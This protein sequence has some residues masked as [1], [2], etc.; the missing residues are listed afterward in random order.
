MA[1]SASTADELS[2]LDQL[3]SSWLDD[4]LA[5]NPIVVGVERGEGGERRW[6]V[7]VHGD[8]KDVYS[9][10]LTLG[11]RT[12]HY[13]TYFMPAPEENGDACFAHLLRRNGKLYGLAFSIGDEDAIFL[14]GQIS[15][16]SIS[17]N[18]LDRVLGTI[19]ATVELCFLSALRIGFASRFC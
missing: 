12:L 18:E 5:T 8:D 14:G 13:E 6:Y 9:I 2:E 3:I 4:Q 10:W 17:G 7:R 15:N 11:Q 16:S 19:Y 1:E